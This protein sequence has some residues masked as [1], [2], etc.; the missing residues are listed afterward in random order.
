MR[1]IVTNADIAKNPIDLGFVYVEIAPETGKLT[2]YV[3]E[4]E[5]KENYSHKIEVERE[6]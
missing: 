1:I 6:K 3:W 4:D 2:V 5:S